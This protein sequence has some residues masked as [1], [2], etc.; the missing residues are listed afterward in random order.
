MLSLNVK[1]GDCKVEHKHPSLLSK[2]KTVTNPMLLMV[3]KHDVVTCGKQM[4]AFH[5][6]VQSGKVIVFE[7]C[8]HTPHYEKAD[9]FAE[10]VIDFLK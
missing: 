8:G 3:G 5:Q 7:E 10:A 2:L 1:K 4:Q 9:L 6:N